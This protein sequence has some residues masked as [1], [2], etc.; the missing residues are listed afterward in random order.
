MQIPRTA[1]PLL[2]AIG[3]AACQPGPKTGSGQAAAPAAAAPAGQ[4]IIH[5][6][7][8]Y[9]EKIKMR[10][11][12]SL[13]VQ[14]IDNLVADA[15]RAVI[16]E[17][18]V[19]GIDH[20]SPIAFALPYDRPR[21]RPDGQYGL[22]AWMHDA[23]GALMFV[24][25]T[26][27]PVTPGDARPVELPMRMATGTGPEGGI[28]TSP[29]EEARARGVGFRGVGNEPGWFVEVDQGDAPA[30]RATLDYGERK[31][32]VAQAHA[33]G[34]ILGYT[35]K[36]ADGVLV[37]LRIQRKTCSDGMSDATYPAA[38]ELIVGDLSYHGCGRF[39]L[40]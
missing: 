11:G 31:L 13:R 35:G 38:A 24:T 19:T 29:W 37:E 7:A 28:A 25:D 20:G 33:L 36:T 12:A 34:K 30:L 5:G 40:E 16:A 26:R 1:L 10:P 8:T 32:E 22:H 2:V 9:R 18:T 17:T 15:P 4:A 23:D 3:L 39:L 6:T 14:L 21:L 27:I